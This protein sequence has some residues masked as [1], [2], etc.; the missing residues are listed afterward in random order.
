VQRTKPKRRPKKTTRVTV[1]IPSEKHRRLKAIAA[2]KGETLQEFILA[3]VDDKM[4]APTSKTKLEQLEELVLVGA[5]EE[6]EISST[7]Y[8]GFIKY[9]IAIQK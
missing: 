4:F 3:C 5:I 9:F 2:L 1:D 6:S 7:N 8:R